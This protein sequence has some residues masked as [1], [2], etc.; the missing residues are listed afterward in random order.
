M[1]TETERGL[2]TE[3]TGMLRTQRAGPLEDH[4]TSTLK[5]VETEDEGKAFVCQV[6][7]AGGVQRRRATFRSPRNAS[8]LYSHFKLVHPEVYAIIAPIIQ[9][10]QKN[11]KARTQTGTIIDS[12]ARSRQCVVDEALLCL[13]AAP[14]VPTRLLDNYRFQNSSALSV[15]KLLLLPVRHSTTDCGPDSAKPFLESRS[16]SCR[17]SLLS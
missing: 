11:K 8:N 13:F 16:K 12:F 15:R 1:T 9:S 17:L 7:I 10:R 5:L 3:C 2:S 4:W 6:C 14:D